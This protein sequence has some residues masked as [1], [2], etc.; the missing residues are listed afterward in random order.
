MLQS[1]VGEKHLGSPQDAV[2]N[3]APVLVR[4]FFGNWF[5]R[6]PRTACRYSLTRDRT[7][8]V[9][10]HSGI[11][12]LFAQVQSDPSPPAAHP[13]SFLYIFGVFFFVFHFLQLRTDFTSN[14]AR[15]SPP[16]TTQDECLGLAVLDMWRLAQEQQQSVKDLCKSVRYRDPRWMKQ[17]CS[18][19]SVT[20]R[21]LL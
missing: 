14:E 16:L 12:Y 2:F 11:A 4:F 7:S 19:F 20:K 15:L 21:C 10:D 5:D 18:D 17:K 13:T 3:K 8:P 6:G 9:L 1:Q